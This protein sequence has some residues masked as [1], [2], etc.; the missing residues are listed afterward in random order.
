MKLY[1][2]SEVP[3][4][5]LLI[6]FVLSVVLVVLGIVVLRG[7][8][9]DWIAGYNAASEQEKASYHIHRLRIIIGILSFGSAAYVLL[10]PLLQVRLMLLSTCVF[11]LF[12]LAGVVLANTWAKK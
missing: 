8:G 6:V 9:D 11:T 10:I 12:A 7:K 1:S 5:V 2:I 4:A 3:A